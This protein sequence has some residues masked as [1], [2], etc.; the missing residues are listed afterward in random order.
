MVQRMKKKRK[1][2]SHLGV[3]EMDYYAFTSSLHGMNSG[4]KMGLSLGTLLLCVGFNQIWVSLLV[5][6]TMGIMNIV[7]GKL[8]FH[9]YAK[10][11]MVPVMFIFL[12]SVAIGVGFS[13]QPAG[14]WAFPLFGWYIYVTREGMLQAASV[15]LKALG[16]VSALYFMTLNTTAAEITGVLQRWHMPKLVVEFMFLIYR[17]IFILLDIQANMKIAAKSRL[18]YR[19]FKTSCCTFGKIASNLLIISVK[20]ANQYY[21]AMLAR[22]YEGNLSFWEEEKKLKVGWIAGMIGYWAMLCVVWYVGIQ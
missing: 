21:D 18:G 16:S 17:F 3:K 11:L 4:F 6:V 10:L 5:V 2:H 13:S 22:C 9:I 20:K 8:S 1:S 12:G 15:F 7:G 14:H 19:D